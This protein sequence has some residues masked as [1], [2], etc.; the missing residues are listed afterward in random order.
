MIIEKEICTGCKKC[1]PYC[2]VEAITW[3]KPDKAKGTKAYSEVDLEK[4]VECSVCFR[5][6]VCAKNAI[7]EQKLEWPRVLR[8]AFSDPIYVHE[9][10]M[11]SGEARRG[12]RSIT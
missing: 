3:H 10:C 11:S 8:K 4:C 5:S 6:G 2:P 1:V 9:E 7:H 12:G